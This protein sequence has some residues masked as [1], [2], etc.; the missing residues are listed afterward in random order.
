M[1]A[2]LRATAAARAPLQGL[3]ERSCDGRDAQENHTLLSLYVVR[4]SIINVLLFFS[5]ARALSLSLSF[6]LSLVI[7]LSL[8]HTH[9]LSPSHTRT[10]SFF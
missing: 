9:F 5:C 4:V 7:S 1:R 2:V 8:T 3:E 6:A 10:F